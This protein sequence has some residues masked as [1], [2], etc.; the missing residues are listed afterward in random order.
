MSYKLSDRQFESIQKLPDHE[1]YDYFLKKIARWEEI[2]S[3]HSPQGW[4]ELSSVDGEECLPI[5]PH[6]EFAKAWAVDD[7]SDC[8]PKAINLEV[9]LER[10]T[11][12]LERD[13]TV[14]AVFPVNEEEG[15]VITPAELE[16]AILA[17]L[18]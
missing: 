3:L 18:Q 15:I 4:V 17:E 8:E 9:W 13:N 11:A 14:L 16:E 2:W 1:R 5:W 12:G 6:P 10:W 7:W